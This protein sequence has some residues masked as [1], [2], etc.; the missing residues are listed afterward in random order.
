MAINTG[1]LYQTMSH[2]AELW[3][4]L[5]MYHW[6]TSLLKLVYLASLRTWLSPLYWPST[7]HDNVE[8][9]S[10][11]TNSNYFLSLHSSRPATT[12]AHR[13]QGL[14]PDVSMRL[15]SDLPLDYLLC[16]ALSNHGCFRRH[17]FICRKVDTEL[18]SNC[19]LPKTMH[20]VILNCP[21]FTTAHPSGIL[22]ILN[23][24]HQLFMR[25]VIRQLWQKGRTYI[26]QTGHHLHHWCLKRPEKAWRKTLTKK[27]SATKILWRILF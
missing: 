3:L 7:S 5:D 23:R 2:M 18:C 26:A 21:P 8:T 12:M 24:K 6:T 16:Q 4:F 11:W 20:R 15:D 13:T 1:R 25:I 9:L 19:R 14:V 17:V 27:S 22:D 10:W